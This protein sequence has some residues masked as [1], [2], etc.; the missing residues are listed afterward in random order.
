MKS[1]T[2]IVLI[3]ACASLVAGC[4]STLAGLGGSPTYAC[5]A[6]EGVLC[7]SVAGVY[8]NSLQ[9]NLPSQRTDNRVAES[10]GKVAPAT[11]TPPA[12]GPAPDS[13]S[14]RSAPRVLRVWLSPW[15]DS[16][17]DLQDQSFL[18]VVVDSGHWLI[19][20]QRAPV[21]DSYTPIAAPDSVPLSAREPIEPTP[22]TNVN[23]PRPGAPS[24]PAST[25]PFM[26]PRVDTDA[27]STPR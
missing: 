13:A 23:L 9:N 6:P 7:T 17:G 14:I 8:A 25:T 2:R 27:E 4:A 15:E 18:Y 10:V 1:A 16:D 19:E 5:K 26:P 21:R 20:Y 24:F 12:S 22:S 3:A 11:R